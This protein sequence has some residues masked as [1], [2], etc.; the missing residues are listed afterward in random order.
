MRTTDFFVVVPSQV[1][2]L[3]PYAVA[4][5]AVLR[6][7]ADQRTG[8][9]FP[10]HKTIADRAGISKTRAR[11]SLDELREAG[12]IGWAKRAGDD[13]SQTSNLYTVFGTR[14]RSSRA[15]PAGSKLAGGRSSDDRGVGRQTTG[16]RSSDD[17]E[18]RP[19][20]LRP[21]RTNVSSVAADASNAPTVVD[22]RPEPQ[23]LAELLASL[24]EANGSTR[25]TVTPAWVT[26][27]ERMNRIDGR[28]WQEIEGA[29][30]WA[31]ADDFWRA[32][33]LSPAKLR[34]KYDQLRLQAKRGQQSK[35]QSGWDEFAAYQP[36]GVFK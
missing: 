16:G 7:F 19:N 34:A 27:I 17:N 13:G 36:Q 11:K 24:I 25:P 15:H 5:Y 21:I 29:I 14:E 32:N 26:A 3:G 1:L 30:R 22:L 6:D 9:A 31:Q 10:S 33:V 4:V 20:E 12:W 35:R 8:E 2:E 23:R 18:L 28:T